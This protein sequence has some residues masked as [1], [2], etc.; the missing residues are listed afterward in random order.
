MMNAAISFEVSFGSGCFINSRMEMTMA[1]LRR[2]RS[3]P[4]DS[5]LITLDMMASNGGLICVCDYKIC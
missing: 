4:A 3:L 2:F 5:G 1:L